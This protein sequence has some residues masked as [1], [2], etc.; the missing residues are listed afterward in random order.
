[1]NTVA[2]RLAPLPALLLCLGCRATPSPPAPKP[3][4]PRAEAP[5]AAPPPSGPVDVSAA[6][7]FAL[8]H[9][10]AIRTARAR[11]D[12]ADAGIGLA[13]TAYLPRLDLLWQEIR[14]TRNNVS[15][16]LLP[17][18]AVVPGIS[19]PVSNRSWDGAWGSTG[20]AMLS[21]EPL[22]FGWRSSNVEAARLAARQAGE[23]VE[24]SRLEAASSAI[25]AFLAHAAAGQALVAVRANLERWQVFAAAV[26]AL[27]DQEL[28]PGVDASRADAEVAQARIQLIQA[29]RLAATSLATL[30][31]A[32]GRTGTDFG[33]DLGPLLELPPAEPQAG[34]DLDA[35]PLLRRQSA[36]AQ[37]HAARREALGTAYYPRVGLHLAYNARGSGF[38]AAGDPLDSDEGLLPDRSNVVAGVSLTYALMDRFSLREKERIEEHLE[39]AERARADE[40]RLHL[41]MQERRILAHQDAARR[42]AENTPVQLKA[43]REAQERARA[44]YDAGLG[45]LTEVSEAQRLLAQAEIDDALARLE[46]WRALGARA[47][48]RGSVEPFLDAVSKMPRKEK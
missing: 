31:E 47:R 44:R 21:W 24:F 3:E 27:V 46:V 6:V 23:T 18:Q 41:R 17:G 28:R 37:E 32:M 14:A 16:S 26:R 48:V 7:R 42:V 22:D 38:D 34:P 25:D 29:E 19:G 13:E 20:G 4:P 5:P 2:W 8:E 30:A 35:H 36:A 12:A 43:A 39:R 11:A 33:V 9:A 15:G 45:T 1:M 10:P 40:I